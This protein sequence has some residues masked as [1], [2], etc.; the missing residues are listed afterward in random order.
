[1]SWFTQTNCNE[2]RAKASSFQDRRWLWDI[3]PQIPQ[4]LPILME[5]SL[6]YPMIS[7]NLE[8]IR[9]NIGHI[10][11]GPL[12]PTVVQLC[13]EVL[14]LSAFAVY[15]LS[16]WV[17][18]GESPSTSVAHGSPEMSPATRTEWAVKK[19]I[20][21]TPMGPGRQMCPHTKINNLLVK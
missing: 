12:C 3:D 1:M 20:T 10:G 21:K 15:N 8:G 16:T 9:Q 11:L 5:S 13:G 2:P 19:K 4:Y 6:M 17:E 7:E 18:I 14:P